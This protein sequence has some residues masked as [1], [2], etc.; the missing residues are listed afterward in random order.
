MAALAGL[1]VLDQHLDPLQ[2][3]G[4]ALVVLASAIVMGVRR[5]EEPGRIES[6]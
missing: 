2:V 3:V 6:T 5:P 1:I 4:L